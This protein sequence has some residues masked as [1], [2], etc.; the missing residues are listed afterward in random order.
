MFLVS[1]VCLAT[2]FRPA[3]VYVLM[4][5]F[6]DFVLLLFLTVSIFGI[7]QLVAPAFLDD[8]IL[9]AGVALLGSL[10]K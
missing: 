8:G 2:L 7:P 9:L 6:V 3:G 1:I 4:T 5:L 10:D